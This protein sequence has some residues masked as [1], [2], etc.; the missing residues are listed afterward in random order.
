MEKGSSPEE[1]EEMAKKY[2]EAYAEALRQADNKKFK[3]MLLEKATPEILL[4][5]LIETAFLYEPRVL[6]TLWKRLFPWG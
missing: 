2:S 3:T 5:C 1:Y 6:N 4:D